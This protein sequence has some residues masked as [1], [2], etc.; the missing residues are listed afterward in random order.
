MARASS[1]FR[2]SNPN[3]VSPIFLHRRNS[4]LRETVHRA[5]RFVSRIRADR[6][7]SNNNS[8]RHVNSFAFFAQTSF[9]THNCTNWINGKT[10][11]YSF[12]NFLIK[13]CVS[14]IFYGN[15]LTPPFSHFLIFSYF[16]FFSPRF[17]E[18]S[19]RVIFVVSS[20]SH[21]ASF[22]SFRFQIS[23]AILREATD[24]S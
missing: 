17:V 7:N 20:K 14:N 6:L 9:R 11:I 3:F 2:L 24:R 10:L 18:I 4:F 12:F 21:S 15:S 16:E 19:L 13:N 22:S 8:L 5:V 23:Y 1:L